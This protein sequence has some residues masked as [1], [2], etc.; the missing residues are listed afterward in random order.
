MDKNIVTK[1]GVKAFSVALFVVLLTTAH[2]A[3]TTVSIADAVV[4]PDDVVTLPIVIDDITNYGTGTM[5]I[6]YDPSVV[7]VIDVAGSSDSDI[8]VKDIDNTA[9]LVRKIL[10]SNLGG[11]S[12]DVVFANVAF[13][14]VGLGSAPLNLDVVSLYNRSF[15]MVSVTPNDGSITISANGGTPPTIAPTSDS[16]SSGGSTTGTVSTSTPTPVPTSPTS[17]ST[18][19]EPHPE[20]DDAHPT[21][22][23]ESVPH[24]EE[25]DTSTSTPST[26]KQTPSSQM[27]TPGF[28]IVSLITGLLIASLIR[29]RKE[30]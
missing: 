27:S 29:R 21:P 8:V 18:P 2:A 30:Q 4:E 14:A 10:A 9:G 15:E 20:G 6:G 25:T 28:E 19:A 22:T 1:I 12:G 23:P 13:T 5:S 24:E 3:A 7:H 16:G 26:V 17:E 11:V